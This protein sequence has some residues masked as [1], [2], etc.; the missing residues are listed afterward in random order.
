MAR[1]KKAKRQ[2]GK[3]ILEDVFGIPNYESQL[4]EFNKDVNLMKLPQSLGQ[5]SGYISQTAGRGK[6]EG[7]TGAKQKHS[8][9]GCEGEEGREAEE[10]CDYA[11][12]RHRREHQA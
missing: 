4:L 7:F 6:R 10:L 11:E 1:E 12:L 2:Y 5:G 9:Q 3:E 8:L